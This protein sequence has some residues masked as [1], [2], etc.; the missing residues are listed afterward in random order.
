LPEQVYYRAMPDYSAKTFHASFRVDELLLLRRD[1]A[2]GSCKTVNIFR[3]P[4]PDG[5]NSGT[6]GLVY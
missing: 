5:D 6:P 2:S 3:L 1:R 4:P